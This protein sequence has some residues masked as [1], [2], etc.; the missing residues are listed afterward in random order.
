MCSLLLLYMHVGKDRAFDKYVLVKNS[1]GSEQKRLAVSS[2][3][4]QLDR[5]FSPALQQSIQAFP[6]C[7]RREVCCWDLQ[8][9]IETLKSCWYPSL[10]KRN[11][12]E[13]SES[14]CW[15]GTLEVRVC[16]PLNQHPVFLLHSPHLG[17]LQYCRLAAVLELTS[18]LP[19]PAA[20]VL[21]HLQLLLQRDSACYRILLVWRLNLLSYT[22]AAV[23][24]PLLHL[25]EKFCGNKS[26]PLTCACHPPTKNDFSPMHNKPL[27]FI[28]AATQWIGFVQGQTA[29]H[30][31][32]FLPGKRRDILSRQ[33]CTAEVPFTLPGFCVSRF[34]HEGAAAGVILLLKVCYR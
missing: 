27:P 10:G 25:M 29:E 34:P 20:A 1:Q 11:T 12:A 15:H 30:L 2:L 7:Y 31:L 14:W 16:L 5:D 18:L 24:L 21:W 4:L 33:Q 9:E 13:L 8:F 6:G 19:E 17:D 22:K 23:P 26:W 28:R 32:P 3:K